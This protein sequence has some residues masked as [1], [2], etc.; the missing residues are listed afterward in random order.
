MSP[1]AAQT[2]AL[3]VPGGRDATRNLLL[4]TVAFALCFTSWSL[5]APFAKTFKS[6]LGLSYTEA[7]LLTAV[8]VVLGSL[9]RIP[10]GDPADWSD[11]DRQQEIDNNLQSL[12]G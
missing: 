11:D 12:L 7:L 6:D 3:A 2:D 5:I 1:E 9:L 10:L 8:P 4:A